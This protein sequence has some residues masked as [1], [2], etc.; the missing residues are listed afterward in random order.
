VTLRVFGNKT[1]CFNDHEPVLAHS[2]VNSTFTT[3][4]ARPAV[5]SAVRIAR[6]QHVSTKATP[7]LCGEA[8]LLKAGFPGRV[9]A[10]KYTTLKI[11]DATHRAV[12][13]EP[14]LAVAKR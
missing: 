1:H 13:A 3:R 14:A 2:R 12:L 8:A 6:N 10:R 7:Y 4:T 5:R 11:T 9:A